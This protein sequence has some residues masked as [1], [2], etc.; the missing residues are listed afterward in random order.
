M[1][2]LTIMFHLTS[3]TLLREASTVESPEFVNQLA[4]FIPY[5]ELLT[6]LGAIS[7]EYR[8]VVFSVLESISQPAS[9]LVAISVAEVVIANLFPSLLSLL[10]SSEN[11]DTRFLALKIFSDILIEYLSEV[12]CI[13]FA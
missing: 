3:S 2:G 4:G 9:K 5:I 8:H 10:K 12:Y 13:F 7:G 11:G 6:S 1:P